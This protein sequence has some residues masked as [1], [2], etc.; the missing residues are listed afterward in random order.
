MSRLADSPSL[1]SLEYNV[2]HRQISSPA[3]NNPG[4]DHS[5]TL[6][7]DKAEGPSTYTKIC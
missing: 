5:L 7:I 4:G 1:R 6:A 3:S 2:R